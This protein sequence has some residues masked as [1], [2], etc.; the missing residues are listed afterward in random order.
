MSIS[1]EEVA[2]NGLSLIPNGYMHSSTLSRGLFY[3]CNKRI[4]QCPQANLS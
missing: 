3:G 1:I 4:F 2:G